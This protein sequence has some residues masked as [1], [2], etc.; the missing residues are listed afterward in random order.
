MGSLNDGYQAEEKQKDLAEAESFRPTDRVYSVQ[1]AILRECA[2]E[3]LGVDR[4][5]F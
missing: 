1:K 3:L 4:K 2:R 5:K